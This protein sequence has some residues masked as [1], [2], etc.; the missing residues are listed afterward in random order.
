M[1]TYSL[2]VFF[3]TMVENGIISS[4]LLLT[5]IALL[6][7]FRTRQMNNGHKT[8]FICLA[9]YYLLR[10]KN[11]YTRWAMKKMLHLFFVVMLAYV[12]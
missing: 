10:C 9:Y 5:C 2:Y 8:K 6:F 1:F 11:L 12:D 7:P 4:P 3:A